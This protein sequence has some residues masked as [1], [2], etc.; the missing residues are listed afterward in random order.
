MACPQATC[1]PYSPGT[2]TGPTGTTWPATAGGAPPTRNQ[3]PNSAATL[4]LPLP[5]CR[6]LLTLGSGQPGHGGAL[7]QSAVAGLP[8]SSPEGGG[9]RERRPKARRPGP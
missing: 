1:R 4:A 8:P 6:L 3:L 5:L 9:T 2:L 7:A